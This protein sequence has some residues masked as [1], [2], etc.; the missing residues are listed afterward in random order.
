MHRCHVPVR[1]AAARARRADASA[2]S[3]RV[4]AWNTLGSIAGAVGTGYFVLP[5][6]ASSARSWLRRW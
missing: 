5:S 3:A 2:A 4:Y 1:G 6:L